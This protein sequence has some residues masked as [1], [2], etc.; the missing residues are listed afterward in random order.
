MKA[1]VAV[2]AGASKD[3]CLLLRSGSSLEGTLERLRPISRYVCVKHWQEALLCCFQVL[4]RVV[5]FGEAFMVAL[6]PFAQQGSS[7]AISWQ[8]CD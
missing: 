6:C 1:T 8:H 5:S 2:V 7:P 4:C 3:A